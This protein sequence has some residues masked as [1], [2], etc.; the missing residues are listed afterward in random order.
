MRLAVSLWFDH[1]SAKMVEADSYVKLSFLLSV[2]ISRSPA[3]LLARRFSVHYTSRPADVFGHSTKT[4]SRV[5]VFTTTPVFI[6]ANR[7]EAVAA[8]YFQVG[9]SLLIFL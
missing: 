8:S 2:C 3:P 4:L 1:A 6:Q 5:L 7:A 9:G